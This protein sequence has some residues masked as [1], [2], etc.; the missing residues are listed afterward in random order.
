MLK[1][2]HINILGCAALLAGLTACSAGEDSPGLEFAPQ[3]YHSVPYEPLSQI[4]DESQGK[5]L[6][7]RADDRG[8]FFNS[9][10]YNPN[11]INMR[12]P[13][14]GTVARNGQGILPFRLPKD[15]VGGEYYLRQAATTLKNPLQETQQVVD[16]GKIL[17]TNFCYPC[18]GAEGRGDGPVGLVYKGVANLA[19]GQVA[20]ASEGHIFYV[21]THGKGRMWPHDKQISV[22]DRWKIVRYVQTL[23]QQGQ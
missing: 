18:H 8:E 6:S 7:T 5:W 1:R 19:S 17:Y 9:N 10:P 22:E 3:M 16:N 14:E 20:E 13:A 4:T 21:I 23:Q 12:L 2:L 15:T 11:R